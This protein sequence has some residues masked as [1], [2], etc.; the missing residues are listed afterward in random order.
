MAKDKKSIMKG[1]VKKEIEKSNS[2]ESKAHEKKESKSFE[3]GEKE[4]EK[5]FYSKFKNLKK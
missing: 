1:A 2:K 3:S 5:E 4:E